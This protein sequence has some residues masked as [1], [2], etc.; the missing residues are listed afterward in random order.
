[1]EELT[2]VTIYSNLPEVE[3]FV[4][5]KS[6]G[7]K[8]AVDHFFRFDIK[9]EGES[10]ILAVAGECR[11]EGFIRKADKF[12]E[13]YL[14]REEG[15]VLNWFDITERDGYLSVKDKLS[16][17][18]ATEE[19]ARIIDSLLRSGTEFNTGSFGESE[20]MRDMMGGFTFLRLSGMLGAMGI[21]IEKEQLLKINEELNKIKKKN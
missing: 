9:N 8:R 15:A 10:K 1:V 13:K 21:K 17:I 5:G 4:N 18:T 11:D 16:D 7:K 20:A 3:L 19:G 6:V 14:L 12:N 2:R